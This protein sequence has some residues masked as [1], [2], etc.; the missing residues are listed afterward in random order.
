MMRIVRGIG[1]FSILF[2]A[3]A[4]WTPQEEHDN[5]ENQLNDWIQNDLRPWLQAAGP[6]ICDIYNKNKADRTSPTVAAVPAPPGY[7]AQTVDFCD[8]GS[9]PSSSP[10]PPPVFGI[11]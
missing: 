4:C 6:A 8:P 2:L 1:I 7:S 9:E 5:L 3:S 11:D 10:D